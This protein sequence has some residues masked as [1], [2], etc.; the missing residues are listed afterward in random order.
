M[1]FGHKKNQVTN[2]AKLQKGMLL[3]RHSSRTAL[4]DYNDIFV[5]FTNTLEKPLLS[6]IKNPIQIQ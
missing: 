1:E 3:S 4:K 2:G 5:K 6:I